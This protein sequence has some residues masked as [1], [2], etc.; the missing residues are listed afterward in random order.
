MRIAMVSEHA[1]PLAV[2]GGPDAGGQNVHVAALATALA[3]RGH[4]LTVYTRRDDPDRPDRQPLTSG[5][6]VVHVPAGEPRP[7]PKDELLPL[8]APMAEWLDEEWVEN[9]PDLVH[10][11]FWMSGLATQMALAGHH[12]RPATALTFHALGVVK[13][14]HQGDLDTSPSERL[15]VERQLLHGADGIVATCRDEVRELLA[16]DADPE[17]LHV[18]PCGVDLSLFRPE[19]PRADVW[20]VGSVKLL[21]L[22]RIVERKGIQTV[23]A[24]LA[25]VPGAGL[26]V[27]GGPDPS[28]LES[29]GEVRRLRAVAREHGVQ[30][31]VRFL[32][33]VD[34]ERAAVLL[35][36]A[37]ALVTVPWYEPFGI[38]PLEAMA[39][40]T[41]VIASAVGGM[42]DTVVP[43][44]TGVHVPPRRPE[45]LA[46]AV[47]E[48]TRT[49]D[50]LAAMGRAGRQRVS[51][52][53]GWSSVAEDTERVYEHLV[54]RRLPSAEPVDITGRR[55]RS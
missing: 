26:V 41:P 16:L 8:M 42:L 18:V 28:D 43:G 23:I 47:R 55:A 19:G 46:Q 17:R 5:V 13:R 35:R 54:R 50:R 25:E 48:L 20:P 53:Y 27:A 3:E 39:C 31:R 14:R 30:D 10:S 7:I 49:P 21:C 52:Q 45:V 9:P 4:E 40:G 29:D 12:Q 34:K 15:A 38:V 6:E 44:V 2:L 33:C 1:S 51:E 36:S 37:D 24:A 11:H 22:G 32:G